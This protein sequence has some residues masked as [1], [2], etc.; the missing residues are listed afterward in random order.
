MPASSLLG[1]RVHIAGSIDKSLDVAP[2]EAVVQARDFVEHLTIELVKAGATFVIPVDAEK[3]R[4]GDGQ[5]ICFDW[6]VLETISH[7]LMQ[8]PRGASTLDGM[9]L[10]VA[11]Q[12]HKTEGQIPPNYGRLW[13]ELR[14]SDLVYVENAN[15][16]DMNSKRLEIQAQQGDILITLGGGEG[17]LFLANLYHDAGKPVIPLNFP[18]A[19]QQTGSLKLFNQ[20][21]TRQSSERFFRMEDGSL[22]HGWINRINF[23]S[24]H[25]TAHRVRTVMQ[26]L[27]ALER[28]NVFGVRLLNPEH[29][30]YPIVEDYFEGV[31]KP[32]VESLGYKLVIVDGKTSSE[33]SLINLE[34]FTKLHRSNVVIADMTGERPNNF[35]ELGYALGRGHR[36]MVTAE[37]GTHNPFDIQ[38][39]P[40][41]F[42]ELSDGLSENKVALLAYWKANAMRRRIVEPDPLVP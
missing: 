11:V 8:R 6:L 34:I 30:K 32:V 36:V 4:D 42:W 40:T 2:E 31:V 18:I 27:E 13:D 41:H 25:D 29:T 20:A 9:P 23:A 33:E 26:L 22:A 15:Q 21:L 5:P 10:I 35:I 1:R 17:V 3:P 19:S 7:S 38:P 39:V 24:R 12:H 37:K 14:G 16:W 28:P